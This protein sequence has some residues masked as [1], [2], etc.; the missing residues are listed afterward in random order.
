MM[1]FNAK[2]GEQYT[3]RR[4]VLKLFGAAFHV[5]GPDGGVVAF[6]K[7]KAFKLR[8]DIRLYTDESCSTEL[9]VIKARSVIDFSATYDLTTADGQAVASMRRKGLASTFFRDSWLVFDPSG[10]QIGEFKEDSGTLAFLRRYIEL[11]S[12]LIPQQFTLTSGSGQVIA[13]YRTHFNPFVYRLSI[14]V[15]A[16]DPLMDDLVILAAGSLIAAIEGRQN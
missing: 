3:I 14:A 6:C 4:K 11:M 10:K 7:Q 16:D 15:Q 12:L 2:P 13:N 9:M 8:E 5:Y 1:A